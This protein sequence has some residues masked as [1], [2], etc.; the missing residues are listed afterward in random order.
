MISSQSSSALKVTS[1]LLLSFWLFFPKAK[2]WATG[3]VHGYRKRAWCSLVTNCCQPVNELL[4]VGLKLT[5]SS[6]LL[7]K[8]ATMLVCVVLVA[9]ALDAHFGGGGLAWGCDSPLVQCWSYF[10]SV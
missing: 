10:I 8:G 4:F 3:F 5:L 2:M 6:S 9:A 7:H 1:K